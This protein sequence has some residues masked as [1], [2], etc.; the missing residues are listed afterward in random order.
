MNNAAKTALRIISNLLLIIVVLLALLLHGTRL[1]GITPY[2][3]LS[4]S[5]ESVYPTGSLIYVKPT[6]PS[7]LD[8]G[9][10]ITF[11]MA[12]GSIATHRIVEIVQDED[13]KASD[14]FRTKGDENDVVDGELIS[15][16]KVIGRP[17]F[18]IPYLGYFSSYIMTPPGQY[19]AITV[20]I[21]VVIIEIMI[22]IVIDD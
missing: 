14:L 18:C 16:G 10:T 20:A 4:G 15:Q 7:T 1:F 9:D 6:D 3:V 21:A 5:M 13:S 19:I 8:V 22:S 12:N 2:T 17:I 11:R